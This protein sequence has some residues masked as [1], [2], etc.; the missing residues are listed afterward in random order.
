MLLPWSNCGKTSGRF[1]VVKF[2]CTQCDDKMSQGDE[3]PE[4]ELN[5]RD[6]RRLNRAERSFSGSLS[7]GEGGGFVPQGKGLLACVS[8]GG[9]ILVIGTR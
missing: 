3:Y 7:S 8:Q 5:E 1:L 2:T 4:I 6:S 9:G